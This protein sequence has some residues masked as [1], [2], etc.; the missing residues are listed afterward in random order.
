MAYFGKCQ[1]A[2]DE[3]RLSKD[4]PL[5][6]SRT[7]ESKPNELA[8]TLKYRF[9]PYLLAALIL[10]CLLHGATVFSTL[11][12]TYDALIHVFFANHYATDWFSHWN[13]SWYTGF[14]V[15][16][17]PP[18]VHQLMGGLSFIGGLKFGLYVTSIMGVILFVTGVFRFSLLISNRPKAAG[19]AAIICVFST[20]LIETLHL[21]GQLPSIIGMSL[22]L[23]SCPELYQWVRHKNYRALI[24]SWILIAVMV[25]SHHVTPIFGMVFFLFPVIGRALLDMDNPSSNRSVKYFIENLRLRFWPIVSFGAGALALIIFCILPYWLNSKN[26]PISQIPIPHGSRD[27]FFEVGSS[28]LV[29]FLV[30][31]GLFLFLWPLATRIMRQRRLVF[32]GLSLLLLTLLG[33]G[34]TTPIPQ[35]ILGDTAFNILTLDRFTLWASLLILP[36]AGIFAERF[37]EG[38]LREKL[39]HT[40]GQNGYRL[41]AGILIGGYLLTSIATLNLGKLR[42]SQ[43]D[44]IDMLP[45]VNFLNQDEHYKWR[46]LTLG[47]GD[48]MAWLSA[49]TQ[50]LTVDGNYHSARKL[51]ELT[52]KSVE[53]LENSKF[54]GI[55][56]LGSL[57]QFLT[58]PN[59]YSLKYVFSNDKFY[60]PLLHFSGWKRLPTLENGITVWERE[61]VNA[62][63]SQLPV[64]E[65]SNFQSL[66][67]GLV[68]LSVSCIAIFIFIFVRDKKTTDN[69]ILVLVLRKSKVYNLFNATWGLLIIIVFFGLVWTQYKKTQVQSSPEKVVTAYFDAMDFKEFERAHSYIDPESK[70]SL[71]RFMLEI[72]ITDGLLSSY[73]KLES[74]TTHLLE[75]KDQTA[76]VAYRGKWITALKNYEINDTIN[77]RLLEG[78]WYLQPKPLDKDVPED[79][80]LSKNDLSFF[81]Q[82]RRRNRL[83]STFYEDV[84]K[85]PQVTVNEAKLVKKGNEY[86]IIGRIKNNDYHPASM[87]LSGSLYDNLGNTLA[88]FVPKAAINYRLLPEQET[89]FKISF[90]EV[91]WLDNVSK[92]Q[93]SFDP[94]FAAKKQFNQEPESFEISIATTVTSDVKNPSYGLSYKLTT[95]N[96]LEIQ[97]FNATTKDC[98]IPQFLIEYYD[99]NGLLLWTQ[100]HYGDQAIRPFRNAKFSLEIPKLKNDIVTI[101]ANKQITINGNLES[102]KFLKSNSPKTPLPNS[103]L[104]FTIALN[105]YSAKN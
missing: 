86:F 100:S 39:K 73:G 98:T 23:H 103:P 26:N 101:N 41:A 17:Y 2:V 56:G 78:K 105:T 51:P 85:R 92:M 69:Q 24:R 20:S 58:N 38:V 33:T 60:D 10:G 55:E 54:R 37:F 64:P 18:L 53:R 22:L 74:I 57:Q 61:G 95:D 90:E 76:K 75:N 46:Y 42:P 9:N 40:Y 35:L 43:P 87:L 67:W 32:F 44:P 5:D 47:F 59:K 88:T 66:I 79:T 93:G 65:G 77:V 49:Q 25:C 102:I 91:A 84:L 36:I 71:D 3:Y 68:P 29:F 30:P 15:Y 94:D 104:N 81:G 83:K 62:L 31:W 96:H 72:A 8:N 45:I 99:Q 63:P 7:F 13:Q 6:D 82:G 52:T 21:F 70:K 97:V 4:V 11:E 14:T 16:G 19:Y 34:G 80:F 50:A 28:G 89:S 27:N 1:L 48:Q 12:K